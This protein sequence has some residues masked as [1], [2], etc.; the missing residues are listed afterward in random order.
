MRHAPIMIGCLFVA[1]SMI[2]AQ[3]T[4]PLPRR[5]EPIPAPDG[6][7]GKATLPELLKEHRAE[8]EALESTFDTVNRDFSAGG[9]TAADV[10]KAAALRLRI[11]D[12]L[13]RI[14]QKRQP[15]SASS[16]AP[17]GK[18]APSL[19]APGVSS[20]E[21]PEHISANPDRA[22]PVPFA[23]KQIGSYA[24]PVDP[25]GSSETTGPKGIDSIAVAYSLVRAGKYDAALAVYQKIDVKETTLEERSTIQ[26]LAATCM[27]NC[28][29][30]DEATNLYR[31]VANAK[32]DPYVATCAQWQLAMMRWEQSTRDRLEELRKR[33]LVMGTEKGTSP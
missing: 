33:R 25:D 2:G 12:A 4:L 8:R 32:S 16:R 23:P 9:S 30:F 5:L 19:L 18:S 1:A 10:A 15:G 11:Q 29:K 6:G 20:S 17:G 14:A 24:V 26:Y 31:E 13:A 21:S 27:R 28:G 3:E 22:V 7:G